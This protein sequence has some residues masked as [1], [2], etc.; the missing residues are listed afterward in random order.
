LKIT[1]LAVF[2][3]NE[4]CCIFICPENCTVKKPPNFRKL[5][6]SRAAKGEKEAEEGQKP[7]VLDEKRHFPK[8][9]IY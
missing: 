4:S 2:G 7:C 1:A 5:C 8:V 3:T 9:M 6:G